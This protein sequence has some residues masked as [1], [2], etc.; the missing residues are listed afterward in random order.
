MGEVCVRSIEKAPPTGGMIFASTDWRDHKFRMVDGYPEF[1]GVRGVCAKI[2]FDPSSPNQLNSPTGM[3]KVLRGVS[4]TLSSLS[5][6]SPTPEPPASKLLDKRNRLNEEL[7]TLE[8]QHAIFKVCKSHRQIFET[9]IQKN[10]ELIHMY[11]T[12]HDTISLNTDEY[13]QPVS[14][15]YEELTHQLLEINKKLQLQLTWLNSQS[16]MNIPKY[17]EEKAHLDR[18]LEKVKEKLKRCKT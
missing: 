6:D 7:G 17:K 15:L 14:Q 16:D 1:Q 8:R 10:S 2:F 5:L 9:A 12:A 11:T 13:L 3:D 18:E 4:K